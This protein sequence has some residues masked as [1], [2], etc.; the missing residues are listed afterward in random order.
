[1]HRKACAKV[2]D[3]PG[4][5]L[6]RKG[7]EPWDGRTWA[8]LARLVVTHEKVSA[9]VPMLKGQGYPVTGSTSNVRDGK[10]T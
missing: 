6:S 7:G 1:M 4:E 9:C 3:N 8:A 10:V 2:N 5:S